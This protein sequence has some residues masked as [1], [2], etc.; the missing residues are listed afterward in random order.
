MTVYAGKRLN[1]YD[2]TVQGQTDYSVEFKDMYLF[3]DNTLYTINGGYLN[4]PQN[5]KTKDSDGNLVI[6]AAFFEDYPTFFEETDSG[7]NVHSAAIQ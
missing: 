1:I 3:E 2:T 5:Y 6:S 4:I 7:R